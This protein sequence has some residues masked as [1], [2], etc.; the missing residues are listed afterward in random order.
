MQA[1]WQA[2][3]MTAPDVRYR[4]F[5]MMFSAN[6]SMGSRKRSTSRSHVARAPPTARPSP[7]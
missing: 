4:T 2:M 1:F 7:R 5:A 6:R 3:P